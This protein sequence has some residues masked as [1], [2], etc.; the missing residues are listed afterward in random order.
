[1]LNT[2]KNLEKVTPAD[3]LTVS[4]KYI[5]PSV[6]SV[7]VAGD[8]SEIADKLKKFSSTGTIELY[9]VYGTKQSNAPAKALPT[10]VTAKSVIEKHITAVGGAD[11]WNNIKDI[12][13]QMST[14]MMGQAI[15][16]KSIKKAPNKSLE[17]VSAGEMEVQKQVFNGTKGFSS[18][19]GQKMEMDEAAIA[20]AKD[21]ASFLNEL[22]WL[23]PEYKLALIGIEKVDGKDAYAVK[24]TK[25]DGKSSTN[26][27]DVATG[28]KVKSVTTVEAQGQSITSTMIY[29]DY[30]EVKGGL[31]YPYTMK[32]SAGPQNMLLTVESIELNTGIA[33]SVFE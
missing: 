30:K 7:T 9:D 11:N 13:T 5:N 8:K 17:V 33:D 25:P 14:E 10:N 27:Y 24:V 20:A 28:L 3:I 22:A 4:K 26:Y 16:I 31:K 2:I 18:M 15:M 21:E 29:S 6:A 19:M 23:K 12:T 32:Q 1:L